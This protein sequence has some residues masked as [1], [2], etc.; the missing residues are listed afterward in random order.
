[1]VKKIEFI[2]ESMELEFNDVQDLQKLLKEY[3]VGLMD[4]TIIMGGVRKY[5]NSDISHFKY[6]KKRVVPY[7]Q[8]VVE[9]ESEKALKRASSIL[10]DDALLTARTVIYMHHKKIVNVSKKDWKSLIQG[11]N[12]YILQIESEKN[13]KFRKWEEGS[14]KVK[15]NHKKKIKNFVNG[16]ENHLRKIYS[17]YPQFRKELDKYLPIVDKELK[18]SDNNKIKRDEKLKELGGSDTLGSLMKRIRESSSSSS[19]SSQSHEQRID[20]AINSLDDISPNNE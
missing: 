17:R 4:Q 10:G 16:C 15:Q 3:E 12:F 14:K 19:S 7:E 11:L 20:D 2:D 8:E 18:K 5:E 1:M 13:R 6:E 9:S